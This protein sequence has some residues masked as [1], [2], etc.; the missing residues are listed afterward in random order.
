MGSTWAVVSWTEPNFIPV[1][2]Q[3]IHYEIMYKKCMSSMYNSISST[4]QDT[5]VNITGLSHS[6]CYV[7]SVNAF[8]N[9]GKGQPTEVSNVT[10]PIITM[11]T[12][13]AEPT[14]SA[15]PPTS[16]GKTVCVVTMSHCLIIAVP[17]GAIAGGAA[18]GIVLF[19]LI[20]MIVIVV[21]VCMR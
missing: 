14:S 17:V 9:D 7:F 19:L 13:T 16:A 4:S 20:V 21:F 8:N 10:L 2:S 1:H 11:T 18:A 3:Y 12:T 5:T 15:E 6:T